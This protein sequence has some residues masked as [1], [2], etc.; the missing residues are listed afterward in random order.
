MATPWRILPI[1]GFLIHSGV[2][3]IHKWYY[4]LVG[5]TL[6]HSYF[7][8][9]MTAEQVDL[10]VIHVGGFFLDLTISFWLFFDKTRPAAIF[11]CASFHTMNSQIFSIGTYRFSILF[12]FISLFHCNKIIA[13]MFPYVCLVTLPLFCDPSWPSKIVSEAQSEKKVNVDT[14]QA[15]TCTSCLSPIQKNDESKIT[16]KHYLVVACLASHVTIQ[17]VLPYSHSISKVTIARS[18]LHI[19]TF[20]SN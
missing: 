14:T 16:W 1:T 5:C 18:F 6:F 19:N 8:L 7:R 3:F 17:A 9:F 10:W 11:F 20:K 15:T 13:G 4:V 12:T 2:P